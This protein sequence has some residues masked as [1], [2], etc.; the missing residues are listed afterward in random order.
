VGFLLAI[1]LALAGLIVLGLVATVSV[2]LGGMAWL[3]LDLWR[4]R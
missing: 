3:G 2:V 1:P 4:A